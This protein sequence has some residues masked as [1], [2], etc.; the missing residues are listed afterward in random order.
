MQYPGARGV[1]QEAQTWK[2]FRS[3]E[4]RCNSSHCIV[5]KFMGLVVHLEVVPS[6]W[7]RWQ[8]REQ[9]WHW[10]LNQRLCV[11]EHGPLPGCLVGRVLTDE[12]LRTSSAAIRNSE[13]Q[14]PATNNSGTV[15]LV[16]NNEFWAFCVAECPLVSTE[17]LHNHIQITDPHPP[18]ESLGGPFFLQCPSNFLH[19]KS[20]TSCSL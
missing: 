10:Q 12:E 18:P 1:Y 11:S 14:Q 20:S 5:E 17:Y 4:K 3:L 7:V 9:G 8:H 15:R 13:R 19:P 16:K 2:R 6:C